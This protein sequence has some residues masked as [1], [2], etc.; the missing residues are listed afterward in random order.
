MSLKQILTFL[1]AVVLAVNATEATYRDDGFEV[2]YWTKPGAHFRARSITIQR[3]YM[4]VTE[5]TIMAS[6]TSTLAVQAVPTQRSVKRAFLNSWS[7]QGCSKGEHFPDV[8]S[9]FSWQ[10]HPQDVSGA[11]CQAFCD[12]LGDDLAATEDGN[13]CW[14][15]KKRAGLSYVNNTECNTPCTAAPGEV[16]GGK[17]RLSVYTKAG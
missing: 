12:E 10:L 8:I 4:T 13:L 11:S 16:C 6:T 7:Y 9:P 1:L 5:T 14:C 17:D 15:G 2:F 3:S